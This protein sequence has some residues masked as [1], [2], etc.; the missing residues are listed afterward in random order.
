MR[1]IHARLGEMGSFGETNLD[2]TTFAQKFYFSKSMIIESL[3]FTIDGTGPIAA[4]IYSADGVILAKSESVTIESPRQLKECVLISPLKVEANVGYV[5]GFY[6]NNSS[7]KSATGTPHSVV[8]DDCKI[9]REK[10]AL[11]ARGDA[12]PGSGWATDNTMKIGFTFK[13]YDIY[14]L[15]ESVSNGNPFSSSRGYMFYAPKAM[16]I[17]KVID[18]NSGGGNRV[19]ISVYSAKSVISRNNYENKNFFPE[20]STPK[21]SR[22]VESN[23]ELSIDLAE[24]EVAV[25]LGEGSVYYGSVV[26]NTVSVGG[27]L[28]KLLRV[29]SNSGFPPQNNNWGT[30]NGASLGLIDVYFNFKESNQPPNP[31]G[32]II[33]IEERLYLTGESIQMSW[34]A[35]ADPDGD[36]VKYTLELFNGLSWE[37]ISSNI[38][39]ASYSV[40]LPKLNTDKAQFRVKATDSKGGQSDYTVSNIFII[41]TQLAL[42]QDGDVVKAYQEGKWKI[43]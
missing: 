39:I 33:G 38:A 9:T 27:S 1:E 12:F 22:I 32:K 11:F 43:I 17:K 30:E 37:K 36:E 40:V 26:N 18:R 8:Y 19:W 15:I 24:G 7:R 21:F 23:V 31:P 5:I 2:F 25:V 4:R 20:R 29:Y 35:S 34:G 14:N 28:F 13:N 6:N 42:I 41:A 10:N 3:W 16:T